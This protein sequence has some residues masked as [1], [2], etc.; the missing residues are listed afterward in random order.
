MDIRYT[1]DNKKV[2]LLSEI[3]GGNYLVKEVFVKEDGTE[4]LDGKEFVVKELFLEHGAVSWKDRAIRDL[5]NEYSNLRRELEY[6]IREQ[7]REYITEL[8]AVRNR[9]NWLKSVAREPHCETIKNVINT[10][11]KFLSGESMWVV[12]ED[13]GG[14]KLYPFF[15][16]EYNK[17]LDGYCPTDQA[18]NINWDTNMNILS[19]FGDYKGGLSWNIHQYQTDGRGKVVH[20]FDTKE[21]ALQYIQDGIDGLDKYS[22]SVI[23]NIKEF[24]LKPCPVLLKNYIEKLH[25]G[26][27]EKREG[28]MKDVMKLDEEIEELTNNRL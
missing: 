28:L 22:D 10:L 26:K 16:S 7:K 25:K 5:E 18:Y 17:L 14:Y 12:M 20:F 1:E 24:N 23:K 27:L 6:K 15:P 3:A 9:S 21:E 2:T 13:W 8:N 11:Y 19:L 4:Y